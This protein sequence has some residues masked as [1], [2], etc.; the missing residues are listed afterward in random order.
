MGRLKNT[1]LAVLVL[2][3]LSSCGSFFN[4][5]ELIG[6]RSGGKF[7]EKHPYGMVSIPAGSYAVGLNN[8]DFLNSNVTQKRVISLSSFWMDETEITNDEYR[9]FVYWVRDSIIR[10]KL[11]EQFPEFLLTDKEGN[12]VEPRRLNWKEKIDYDN[13]EQLSAIETLN[14]KG[15]DV[16]EGAKDF[17]VRKLNYTWTVIDYKTAVK[18]SRSYDYDEGKYKG[19]IRNEK[20]ELVDIKGRS[21]L[22]KVR[23]DYI[24]PDTLCWKRD[25]TYSYNEPYAKSYF[26]HP[27]YDNYPVVGVSWRQARAFCDWRTKLYNRY[28]SSM[29]KVLEWRLPT[30][31][32]WEYAA[33]GGLKNG[34]YPWGGPY[35]RNKLGCFLANFKPLRGNYVGDGSLRTIKVGS[36]E[37]NGFGLYDMAGNVSEWTSTAY[38]EG[39]YD[40]IHDMNPDYKY[41]ARDD[42]PPVLKR[43]VIRGGSWKDI[44]IYLEC[45]TRTYEYQDTTKSY[46]GF[47][48][49]RSKVND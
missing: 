12:P 22:V 4:Q 44:G 45:G 38:N 20:G 46:V 42:D 8:Q 15:L 3:L 28:E 5:G 7:K 47:R 33:R 26:N 30:E 32:E 2:F 48:C 21:S 10:Q 49:V 40:F 9:Q 1:S 36:Y 13:E 25:F 39:S 35:L 19:Q 11:S 14:Y 31:F 41:E 29:S 27:G 6:T 43:K 16:L 34:I 37:A 23:R 18:F 17:D 24:Y